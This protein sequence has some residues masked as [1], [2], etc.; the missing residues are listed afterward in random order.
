[1]KSKK[2]AVETEMEEMCILGKDI[3]DG[4]YLTTGDA[5]KL[6]SLLEKG[7]DKIVELRISRDNHSTTCQELRKQRDDKISDPK[8]K[9]LVF[10]A[11]KLG[12]KKY[13][14][15]SYSIKLWVA[16]EIEELRK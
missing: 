7:L 12:Q 5:Q 4:S 14:A 10:K 13:N 9:Q 3:I 16:G 8:I 11:F 6:V 2:S 15:D 1:M